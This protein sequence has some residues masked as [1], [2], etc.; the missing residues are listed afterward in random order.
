MIAQLRG[1]FLL[2]AVVMGSI[3]EIKAAVLPKDFIV[4]VDL[5]SRIAQPQQVERDLFLIEKIIDEFVER[6]KE[7]YYVFS[8]DRLEIRPI[9]QVFG[10]DGIEWNNQEFFAID[11]SI[12]E[13]AGVGLGKP[14]LLTAVEN[15]KRAVRDLYASSL[16][17]AVQNETAGA[18]V[19]YDMEYVLPTKLRQG[20]PCEVF[21]FTDGYLYFEPAAKRQMRNGTYMLAS[22]LERL[23]GNSNWKSYFYQNCDGLL[24]LNS[25]LDEV[26]LT[27]LEFRPNSSVWNEVEILKEYWL[28][29][30]HDAVR[31]IDIRTVGDDIGSVVQLVEMRFR[32]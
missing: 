28:R 18:D 30:L 27:C 8:T 23:R 7:Q 1:C 12:G 2:L 4:L 17:S 5:S 11:M 14:K 10:S 29:W 22:Q 9:R 25:R 6:Q 13:V 31:G 26:M 32:D 15:L 3:T 20:V 19:W 21:L 16:P 24:L